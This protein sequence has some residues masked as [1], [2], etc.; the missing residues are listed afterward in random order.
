MIARI[1]I[2]ISLIGLN[3]R[4]RWTVKCVREVPDQLT[5]VL[6]PSIDGQQHNIWESRRAWPALSR[7]LFFFLSSLSCTSSRCV[8]TYPWSRESQ[9]HLFFST[10]QNPLKQRSAQSI[11]TPSV[12]VCVDYPLDSTCRPCCRSHD[13]PFMDAAANCW[14]HTMHTSLDANAL[15]SFARPIAVER[16]FVPIGQL[17]HFERELHRICS[18]LHYCFGTRYVADSVVALYSKFDDRRRRVISSTFCISLI[19]FSVEIILN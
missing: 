12:S 18:L 19:Y 15:E 2:Q 3:Y 9:I 13:S 10:T 17:G 16:S 11:S 1:R 14:L 6:V 5:K 4:Y 8:Y 7:F